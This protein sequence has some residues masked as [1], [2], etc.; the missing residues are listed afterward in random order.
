MVVHTDN[1]GCTEIEGGG[2][3][4]LLPGKYYFALSI[5]ASEI[6]VNHRAKFLVGQKPYELK[7]LINSN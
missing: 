5:K 6:E 7:W 1:S 2:Q 3:I 4:Q